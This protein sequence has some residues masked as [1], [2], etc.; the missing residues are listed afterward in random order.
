MQFGRCQL[1]SHF[2]DCENVDT[3]LAAKQSAALSAVRTVKLSQEKKKRCTKSKTKN[4][5]E[6]NAFRSACTIQADVQQFHRAASV[7]RNET[8]AHNQ[9]SGASAGSAG[10]LRFNAGRTTAGPDFR[11]M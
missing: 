3:S 4:R 5:L 10:P 9:S 6:R 8:V 7:R 11:R 1:R 2:F